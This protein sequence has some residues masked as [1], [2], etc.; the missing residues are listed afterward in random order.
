MLK[1]LLLVVSLAAALVGL[2]VR[3]RLPTAL[4]YLVMGATL[5][6]NALG[7]LPANDATDQLAELGVIFLM[8]TVGLE[9]AL[10]TLLASW[11]SIVGLGALQVAGS[12]G[13]A[14][15]IAI[16]AGVAWAPALLL[17]AALAMSSTAIVLK[18]LRDQGELTSRHGKLCVAILIFQD[19]VALPLMAVLPDIDAAAGPWRIVKTVATAAIAFIA[20]AWLADR[21]IQPAFR[22]VARQRSSELFTLI[23]LLTVIGAAGVAKVLGLSAPLGAFLAGLVLG[24]T[25]Y[26]HQIESDLHPFQAVLL[27]LFFASI[28]MLLDFRVLFANW[29]VIL[30]TLSAFIVIKSGV[31]ATLIRAAGH[32]TDI[33]CRTGVM[34]GH[35]GEFG[36]LL[37]SVALSERLLSSDAAQTVLASI[38]ASMFA[39]P[40][41]IQMSGRVA[42]MVSRNVRSRAEVSA[43]RIAAVTRA[44]HDHVVICGFGRTG[45]NVAEILRKQRLD[46]VAVDLDPLRVQAAQA[47]NIPIT[48]GDAT[49]RIVLD[50]AGIQRARALVVTFDDPRNATRIVTQARALGSEQLVVLVRTRDEAHYD[51]LK[52]AGATEVL[53]D[54]LE[55]SLMLGAKLLALLGESDDAIGRALTETRADHYQSLRAPPTPPLGRASPELLRNQ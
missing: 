16:Q 35:G 28:G 38:I 1:A 34:L 49:R 13:L 15:F 5:G 52:A 26:R 55:A 31:I 40:L 36:L 54:G 10:P 46:Y 9:F 27:G 12:G 2:L 17:G 50:A 19:L 45:R 33:A 37:A 6:P 25:T 53:P 18:Q 47:A 4:G 22:W 11:R 14:A 24:E 8:F 30:A 20:L 23:S 39:A 3:W 51:A 21:L 32:E 7:W 41:T 29:P 48:Y 44:A 43:D 42:R